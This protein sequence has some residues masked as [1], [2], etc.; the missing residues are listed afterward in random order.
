MNPERNKTGMTVNALLQ[1]GMYISAIISVVLIAILGFIANQ[2]I[3]IDSTFILW[4]VACAITVLI[5][6]LITNYFVQREVKSRILS[7]VDVCRDYSGGDRTVRASVSGDD[8]F[9][10][11]SM[12]LNTL[13]DNQGTPQGATT[14]GTSSGDAAALQAQ[15]EK[16]LQE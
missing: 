3:Q 15:I 2:H 1:T 10:M 12:S 8:E 13:L 9:S 16:L 4:V 11:L 5:G 14:L 7:L 6:I